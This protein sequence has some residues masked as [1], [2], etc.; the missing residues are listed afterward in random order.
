MNDPMTEQNVSQINSRFGKR[1]KELLREAEN[2][3]T[4]RRAR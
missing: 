4:G 1:L 2:P 3:P